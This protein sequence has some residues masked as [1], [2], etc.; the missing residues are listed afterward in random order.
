MEAILAVRPI[1]RVQVWSPN[2]GRAQVF[3]KEMQEKFA[4]PIDV[5]GSAKEAAWNADIICTVSSS[6]TPVLRGEWVK[7]G[8]H[9]NAVGACRASD[10]ELDSDLVKRSMFY[11]DR[12]ES[13]INESGDYLI[14]LREGVIDQTHIIGEI[15]EL[16]TKRLPAQEKSAITI[17]KSLGLSIEDL[18]AAHFIFQEAVRLNK[19]TNISSVRGS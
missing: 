10:R 5:C 4:L 18:A 2:T 17:F 7:E 9:I 12:I 14:P 8:A 3:K 19:G 1:E 15:G 13:T 6:T 11:V 16:L